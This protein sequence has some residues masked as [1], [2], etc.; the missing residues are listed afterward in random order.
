MSTRWNSKSII[1]IGNTLSRKWFG[2]Y[3]ARDE[4]HAFWHFHW[5]WKKHKQTMVEKIINGRHGFQPLIGSMGKFTFEPRHRF[6]DRLALR[7]IWLMIKPTVQHLIS[8]YCLH[9]LGPN[10]VHKARTWLGN[11]LD[12]H[13]YNYVLRLDI[14][15]Y[16]ASINHSILYEQLETHFQDPRLLAYFK[17]IVFY[18]VDKFGYTFKA[19]K[20]IPRQSSLSNF[21]AAMYL[22]PL[23]KCFENRAGYFYLRYNDDIIIMCKTKRQFAKAKRDMYRV[24]DSLKLTLSKE[25]SFMGAIHKGF[26]FLGQQYDFVIPD[27]PHPDA[28]TQDAYQPTVK[29]TLHRRTYH[30]AIDK[31]L[32]QLIEMG[33]DICNVEVLTVNEETWYECN[34]PPRYKYSDPSKLMFLKQ[35]S[36]RDNHLMQIFQYLTHGRFDGHPSSVQEY[37]NR[38]LGW[39]SRTSNQSKLEILAECA[40]V[41]ETVEPGLAPM[42]IIASSHVK[43]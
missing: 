15:S 4:R 17:D 30:R 19:K 31:I 3:K 2:R 20:G 21:F 32:S 28:Q 34:G 25:K 18:E 16:Y 6:E 35:L 29:V 23:D 27:V 22:T 10:G 9:T 11:V 26:H 13:Q 36:K 42:Y 43:H 5:Y 8:K 7:V 1:A 41:L 37:I 39:W 24:L 12:T 38:W 40:K 14:K 33:M